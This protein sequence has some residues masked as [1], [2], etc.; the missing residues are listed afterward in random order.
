MRL[1]PLH[2]QPLVDLNHF[3]LYLDLVPVAK[4]IE[5]NYYN[6]TGTTSYALISSNQCL[7][8]MIT[9]SKNLRGRI[10]ILL[11]FLVHFTRTIKFMFKE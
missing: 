4:V 10:E 7:N 3:L 1:T 11:E 9:Q 6:H 5:I 8:K 2:K